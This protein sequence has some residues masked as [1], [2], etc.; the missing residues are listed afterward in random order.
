MKVKI[1]LNSIF[2][3]FLPPIYSLPIGCPT[4][5]SLLDRS[6]FC[7]YWKI[8]CINNGSFSF[9]TGFYGDYVFNRYLEVDRKESSSDLQQTRINTNAGYLIFNYCKRIDIFTTLGGSSFYIKT[10]S[11]A[12]RTE[13]LRAGEYLTIKTET[14]FSWSLGARAA[15]LQWHCFTLGVEGQYFRSNPQINYV[16]EEDDTPLYLSSSDHFKYQEWQV[17]AALSRE[18]TICSPRL[19]FV[20]YLGVKW[21]GAKADMGK[22]TVVNPNVQNDTYVLYGLQNKKSWGYAVGISL[23]LNEMLLIL[24]ERRFGDENGLQ[25]N[26]QIHF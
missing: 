23:T 19:S 13:G 6:Y 7:E 5:P 8:P 1:F 11:S 14:S 3:L 4:E 25:A 24:V 16:K 17:G 10:P 22:R 2:L 9:R 18:F 21:A 12:F 26:A 20:P 15:L